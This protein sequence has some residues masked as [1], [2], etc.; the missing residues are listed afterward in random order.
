[1]FILYICYYVCCLAK[2]AL[3]M[4]E[5]Q[6]QIIQLFKQFICC[7][8]DIYLIVLVHIGECLFSILVLDRDQSTHN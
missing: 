8:C 1:M 7:F 3:I 5:N 6:Q 4:R 2:V